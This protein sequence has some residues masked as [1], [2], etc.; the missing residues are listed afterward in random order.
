MFGVLRLLALDAAT[1]IMWRFV[2][3]WFV[4]LSESLF[5]WN[6]KCSLA[7]RI[8][9]PNQFDASLKVLSTDSGGEFHLTC[10]SSYDS[11]GSCINDHVLIPKSKSSIAERKHRHICETMRTL[12]LD[13]SVPKHYWADAVLTAVYLIN[14]QQPSSHLGVPSFLAFL[15]SLESFFVVN[16]ML[17]FP[18]QKETNYL[19]V[20][21]RVFFL[22]MDMVKKRSL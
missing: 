21:F 6:Q 17:F 19:L 8:W 20:L 5:T 1:L 13:M 22:G 2:Y 12:L 10:R 3:G 9:S 14:R 7:S 18:L 4:S 16:A 15:R 11:M